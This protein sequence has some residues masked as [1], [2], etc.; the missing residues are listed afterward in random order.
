MKKLFLS[1]VIVGFMASSARAMTVEYATKDDHKAVIAIDFSWDNASVILDLFDG[2][3]PGKRA[4]VARGLDSVVI[5]YL[6]FSPRD[7]LR[8]SL[9]TYDAYAGSKHYCLLERL[10]YSEKSF[11]VARK[12]LKK[13]CE[14]RHDCKQIMVEVEDK[15]LVVGFYKK[16]GFEEVAHITYPDGRGDICVLRLQATVALA[17]ESADCEQKAPAA[18][19]APKQG[20]GW[21]CIVM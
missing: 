2:F 4:L 7:C 18:V 12:L 15:E 16:L 9:K 10:R 17:A 8:G 1:L 11:E 14:L 6:Y 5:G 3:V 13:L 20:G 19:V 21:S